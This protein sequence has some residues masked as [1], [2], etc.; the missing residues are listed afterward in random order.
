[1][2]GVG[3]G[4][5]GGHRSLSCVPHGTLH[6][7]CGEAP[8]QHGVSSVHTGRGFGDTQPAVS[9]GAEVQTVSS[10]LQETRLRQVTAASGTQQ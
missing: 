10:E 8:H 9:R 4:M 1:M 7:S 2:A 3:T 6:P 5:L